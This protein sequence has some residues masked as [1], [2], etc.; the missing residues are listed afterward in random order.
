[1]AEE[2]IIDAVYEASRQLEKKLESKTFWDRVLP[3]LQ[4]LLLIGGG[5]WA[6]FTYYLEQNERAKRPATI[7]VQTSLQ[8]LGDQRGFQF[9]RVS[10][11][12]EN[13]GARAFVIHSPYTVRAHRFARA[14]VP[15]LVNSTW[16]GSYA[17]VRESVVLRSGEAFGRGYWFDPG[18]KDV[19]NYVVAVPAG[20]FDLVELAAEVRHCKQEDDAVHTRWEQAPDGSLRARTF[21][22]TDR[23]AEE[24]ERDKHSSFWRRDGIAMNEASTQLQLWRSSAIDLGGSSDGR[25]QSK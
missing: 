2:Q 24:Y 16:N 13:R 4:T 9:I 23:G 5:L 20:K 21:I 3:A 22:L 17:E 8:D 7:D 6:V 11:A 12:V 15:R 14:G 18:E 1:M 25:A 19:R 10:I